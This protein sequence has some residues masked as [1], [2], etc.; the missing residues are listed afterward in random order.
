MESLLSRPAVA[1]DFVEM[2]LFVC[3][4]VCL[5]VEGAVVLR[6]S[7]AAGSV[8][9][10]ANNKVEDIVRH[11]SQTQLRGGELARWNKFY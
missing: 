10:V 9:Q 5:F 8:P 1:V 11:R 7:H 3:L 2:F 4:F 6:R